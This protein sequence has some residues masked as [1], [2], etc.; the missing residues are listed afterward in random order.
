MAMGDETDWQT[1]RANLKRLRKEQPAWTRQQLATALSRSLAWV[2]K[3]L[4]RIKT[5]PEDEDDPALLLPKPRSPKIPPPPAHPLIVERLLDIRDHPPDHL[6]RTPGPRA[7]AYFLAKDSVLVEQGL[8]PPSSSSTSTIWKILVNNGRIART[9]PPTPHQLLQRPGPL[10]NFQLDFKDI[11]YLSIEPDGK[12]A[13][14]LETLNLIDVGTDVLVAAEVSGDFNAETALQTVAS[15]VTRVGLP[16]TVTFDRDPRWVGS[17]TGRDFPSAFVKFWYCLEVKVNLCPPHRPDLNA[18]VERYH[19]SY[20]QECLKVHRP[21]SLLE[22]REVTS[23][24]K[25]HY[26]WQRPHQSPNCRNRPPRVAFPELPALPSVPL[27]IDPD[28]WLSQCNGQRFVRKVDYRGTIRVDKYRY[29]PG[30]EWAGKFVQVEVAGGTRQLVIWHKAQPLK[31]LAIKGLANQMLSWVDFL[32][33]RLREAQ[34]ERRLASMRATTRR[35]LS[36]L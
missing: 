8:K 18:I 26:N 30:R 19:R 31:Q 14:L 25:E 35:K 24:F 10:E 27:L 16:K 3:W 28:G 15:V 17:H 2:K 1:D 5:S 21:Q 23:T 13:H 20:G 22:A 6:G 9:R 33:L 29:Y 12:K 34:S 7:I 32:V 11:P 36:A 4:K